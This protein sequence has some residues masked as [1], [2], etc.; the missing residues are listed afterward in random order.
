MKKTL[1][2]PALALIFASCGQ[3]TDQKPEENTQAEP[4]VE[5]AQKCTYTYDE[6][7]VEVLWKAY[8]YTD[9]TGVNGALKAFEISGASE[10]D[11]PEA[12][13]S[14]ASITIDTKSV[15][16]GDPTRDPKIIDHFFMLLT[17]G[18]KIDASIAGINTEEKSIDLSITMNGQT[19]VVSGSYTMADNKM[20]ATFDIDVTQWGASVDALNEACEDLHKG[21]DGESILWPDVT[22]YLVTAFNENCA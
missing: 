18:E 10:A 12:A 4:Q 7:S 20:E 15:D 3:S 5:E 2:V 6:S 19:Q 16:S 22:I 11:S 1:L 13:I 14:G 17:D 21:A 9:K 8:K